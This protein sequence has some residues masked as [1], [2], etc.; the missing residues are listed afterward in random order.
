MVSSQF[1]VAATISCPREASS[2]KKHAMCISQ[3]DEA[4]E[5]SERRILSWTPDTWTRKVVRA[6][7]TSEAEKGRSARCSGHYFL[8]T[9]GWSLGWQ[10]ILVARQASHAVATLLRGGLSPV[11]VTENS[12]SMPP[13]PGWMVEETRF[14]NWRMHCTVDGRWQGKWE[15]GSPCERV[16]VDR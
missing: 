3:D 9:P 10:R 8:Q 16:S 12:G 7:T 5:C 2:R 4:A 14:G 1:A 15:V 11:A 13:R 6:T